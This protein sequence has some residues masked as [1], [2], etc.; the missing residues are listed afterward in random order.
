[1]AKGKKPELTRRLGL[2]AELLPG[3]ARLTVSGTAEV[4][5]ENHG[6]LSLLSDERVEIRSRGGAVRIVGRELTLGFMDR[7]RI[8]VRGYIVAA[9]LI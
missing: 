4:L 7:D 8:I 9:E 5:V 6:G 3:A 2:P 1:M